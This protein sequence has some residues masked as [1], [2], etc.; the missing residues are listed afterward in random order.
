MQSWCEDN[1]HHSR[2]GKAVI[3]RLKCDLD[4][5]AVIIGPKKPQVMHISKDLYL[6]TDGDVLHLRQHC[7]R[8]IAVETSQSTIS[9]DEYIVATRGVCLPLYAVRGVGIPLYQ[10]DKTLTRLDVNAV[11]QVC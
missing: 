7:D 9:G 3:R 4:R 2:S 1:K 6:S 11:G 8:V 10:P 5:I